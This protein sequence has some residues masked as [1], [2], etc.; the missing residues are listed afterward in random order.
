M[1]GDPAGPPPPGLIVRAAA[2]GRADVVALL[3]EHGAGVDETDGR[4]TALHEA[5]FH[6][7]SVTRGYRQIPVVFTPGDRSTEVVAR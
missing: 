3:L 5:A 4:A 2:N 7:N 1:R 6:G